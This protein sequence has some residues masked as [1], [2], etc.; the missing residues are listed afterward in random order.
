MKKYWLAGNHRVGDS[1]AH[2][3]F[4]ATKTNEPNHIIANRYNEPVYRFFMSRT[5]L[6]I[7]GLKVL[8]DSSV[9]MS[10]I[11]YEAY[12]KKVPQEVYRDGII[13]P[14]PPDDGTVML[15]PVLP[16][17]KITRPDA[18]Q[19]ITAQC[20][21]ISPWKR[22]EALFQQPWKRYLPDSKTIGLGCDGERAVGDIM[23]RSPDL[24]EVANVMQG[25]MLH[26]GICSS[27][28]R[29]ASML[30]IPTI[31]CHWD[32]GT[33]S[34]GVKKDYLNPTN[35]DLIKPTAQEIA[36]AVRDVWERRNLS[37]GWL[38]ANQPN[39]YVGA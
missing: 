26:I 14:L 12:M 35:V 20:D 21:S 38:A 7:R 31:M 2:A 1:L 28:T 24:G 11:D 6:N 33:E 9:L 17:I 15:L 30:G 13:L 4:F 19:Y 25:A 8:P 18:I 32:T 5:S 29:F 27:M 16:R 3:R 37:V 34:Q 10:M 39:C 23:L 36:D 22:V